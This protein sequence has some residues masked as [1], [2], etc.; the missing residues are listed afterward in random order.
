M[1]TS[2]LSDPSAQA[3]HQAGV[4]HPPQ[5]ALLAFFRGRR[6][7]IIPGTMLGLVIAV[8]LALIVT[9]SD[10]RA[11]ISGLGQLAAL[12]VAMGCSFWQSRRSLS[13]RERWAWRCVGIAFTSYIIA[14][15]IVI[16]LSLSQT[17]APAASVADA[18]FLPFYPLIAI[19]ILLLPAAHSSNS[20]R[21]RVFLDAGIAV[22]AL[23]SLGLVLLIV[24]RYS[25][26][27]PIDIVF[28]IYPI[29]DLAFLLILSALIIRGIERAYGTTFFWLTIGMLCFIYAD[30][31]FNYL[32]LPGKAYYTAG[33][34]F[35]DPF[36]IAGAF[37]FSLAPLYLLTQGS[38][39]NTQ[40]Q[41]LEQLSERATTVRFYRS[42]GQILL[43][44]APVVV[45][46][47]L[48]LILKPPAGIND[49]YPALVVL[50]LLVVTLII[51]RQWLTTRDLVDARIATKRAQQL[52]A[53][54]DQFITNVNHEL[55]TPMM[56]MQG[57]IEIL[58]ELEQ[59]VDLDKRMD[60]LARARRANVALVQLL[61]SLLDTRRID[62][63]AGDFVPEAVNLHAELRT[64][65]T[66]VDPREGNVAE[67]KLVIQ[68]PTDIMIW[69][70][71]TRLQ[72]I[73]TNLISNAIKYSAIGTTIT[74]T[75]QVASD[76]AAHRLRWLK[77]G[78]AKQPMAE[79]TV[80][81]EGLG[82]PPEQIPL[83][84]H[85]FVRLPRDL[86]SRIRGTGLGLY[87]CR[88]FA[89]AMGGTIEVK[90]TGVPGEG[91]TFVLRLPVPSGEASPL[92]S[93][94]VPANA[95]IL[96]SRHI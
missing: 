82:I 93:S 61:Q 28:I 40:W 26:G 4:G 46:F 52:D 31:A 2:L 53:L 10:T 90:S 11:P 42:L 22:G 15:I 19:G 45:L 62:Q 70:E 89:E 50:A 21:L 36:W 38:D 84:F 64:A 43:L 72:Q 55:R 35:V 79:I 9:P 88:V 41:W 67:R 20:A 76:E 39:D 29:A 87:L 58:S 66:L 73:L 68:V 69:G 32:T 34:P 63:E 37:A 14:E 25:H 5:N 8:V 92:H 33:L 81:D 91:S 60:M 86:A 30:T 71:A 95:Y 54:K 65:L 24:P 44:Y 77:I 1:Q 18:F 23:L 78:A 47:G 56:T 6:F 13:Q 7:W 85:R 48:L 83:L 57:Y 74:I 16:F 80:Q 27:A 49:P 75:A 59:Q 51:T 96:E 94:P 3:P 17:A 12:L